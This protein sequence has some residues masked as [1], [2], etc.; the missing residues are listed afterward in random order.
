[1]SERR[2]Q[3]LAAVQHAD[4]PTGVAEV[5]EQLGVHANTARFHLETLVADGI[6][7][8][9]TDLPAGPGR[10]RISYRARPGQAK[11]GARRYRLL[12]EILLS[13]LR[14]DAKP[15]EAAAA[16]GRAWGAHL[17]SRP[18]PGQTMD[19][20]QAIERLAAM[21][22]DLDFDP[23][24]VAEQTNTSQP[25]TPGRIRLRHCPFL[26]LAEPHRDLVCTVHLGLMQ[27]ALTELDAPIT[28]TELRPFAEPAACL[29]FLDTAPREGT[30]RQ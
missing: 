12:A 11:G 8:R 18:A 2:K 25:D 1:M 27:G 19:Q 24:P 13:H 30:S 16:A 9:V 22:E 26:E 3:V 4:G 5:A 29:A 20:R 6:I 14:A 15:S 17:I 21:L 10:P 7:E 28:V 23:E